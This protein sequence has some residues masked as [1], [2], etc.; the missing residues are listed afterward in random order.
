MG[1]LFNSFIA[2][3]VRAGTKNSNPIA[4]SHRNQYNKAKEHKH[5]HNQNYSHHG[6][7]LTPPATRIFY[8]QPIQCKHNANKKGWARM[9]L[10]Q[11]N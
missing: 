2:I 6:K 5:N 3:L 11:F 7:L 10:K 4:F 9:W 8:L 1:M